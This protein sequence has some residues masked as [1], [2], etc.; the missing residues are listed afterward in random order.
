MIRFGEISICSTTKTIT[1]RGVKIVERVRRGSP[2]RPP[3]KRFEF[4]KHLLLAAPN[5][6]TAHEVFDRVYGDDPSGG[7]EVGAHMLAVVVCMWRSR[8]ILRCMQFRLIKERRVGRI[9]YSVVPID[10][11]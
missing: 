10:V 3:V 9:Y 8:G 11:V 1:H 4:L 2:G 5:G 6:L 7:P